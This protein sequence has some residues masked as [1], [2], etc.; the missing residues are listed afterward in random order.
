M[1]AGNKLGALGLLLSDALERAAGD[2]SPSAAAFLLTLLY[3][4]NTTANEGAKVAGISQ[5]TAVR[6][7]DGLVRQGFVKREGRAGHTTVLCITRAGRQ[8]ARLLQTARL[9]AMNDLHVTGYLS[10]SLASHSKDVPA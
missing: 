1:W 7:L 5:S 4:P 2:L 8:R 10:K 3:S 9:K 6:V